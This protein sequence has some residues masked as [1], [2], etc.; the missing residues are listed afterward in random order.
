MA[1]Y[2]QEERQPYHEIEIRQD[3]I[4]PMGTEI[5]LDG[6]KVRGVREIEYSIGLDRVAEVRLGIVPERCNIHT[7][8]NVCL[9]V[10]IDCLHTAIKTIQFEMLLDK[11]FRDAV[12]ASTASVL[13]EK[14]FGKADSYDIGAEIV[15]RVLMKGMDDVS[16]DMAN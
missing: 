15:D 1:R 4:A 11:D 13:I 10:D 3:D 6:N 16:N 14:G 2:I 12:I 8:A 5:Y 7:I 9:D